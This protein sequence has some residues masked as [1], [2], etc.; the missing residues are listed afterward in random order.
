V[1]IPVGRELPKVAKPESTPA[2]KPEA[3]PAPAAADAKSDTAQA[4]KQ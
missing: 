3:K 2:S 1:P 4:K